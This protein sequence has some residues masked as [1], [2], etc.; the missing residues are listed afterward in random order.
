MK[1]YVLAGIQVAVA[2]FVALIVDHP[3]DIVFAFAGG[4]AAGFIWDD[5][6][7]GQIERKYGVRQRFVPE[8]DAA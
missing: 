6:I 1:N 8:D 7:V 5:L 4:I 3:T 2:V